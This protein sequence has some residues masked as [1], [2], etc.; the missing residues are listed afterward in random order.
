MAAPATAYEP[1][2]QSFAAQD[3]VPPKWLKS[4]DYTVD[5]DVI[6]K[7]FMNHYLVRSPY[8]VFPARGDSRLFERTREASALA[9]LAEMSKSR[10]FI[11]S[12]SSTVTTTVGNVSD[13][14]DDPSGAAEDFRSGFSRLARRLGRMGRNAYKRGKSLLL[15]GE[16]SEETSDELT[17]TGQD[18]AKGLLGVNRAYRELARDLGV[19]PYTRNEK[20]RYEIE[21]LANYS[22]AGSLGVRSIFPVLPLLYGAGY[23]ITV[24]NLIWNTHPLDLQ[25]RNETLLRDMGMS[26]GLITRLF[27]SEYHT[28][29][30]QTR[31][32][33]SLGLLNGAKGR[34]VLM[35]S[36]SR[37]PTVSD[38]LFYTRMIEML[39]MYHE[40]RG[41]IEEVFATNRI[42]Y[43]LSR[44]E[45]AV[46]II[47]VDHLRWTR[48]ADTLITYMGQQ[49]SRHRTHIEIW[50]TGKVSP[51]AR[52]K[53]GGK[54][55]AVFDRA[56]NRI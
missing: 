21:R 37:V 11:D 51:M 24:S 3:L 38:A 28:L 1:D 19:D 50:V 8:G 34:S 10:L 53:L 41:G 12:A 4:D 52:S 30:T 47:P 54:G 17:R 20:L 45:R 7:L 27:E 18:L 46:L 5:T 31:V 22:A 13:A 56:G 16:N 2:V 23:L 42:P 55:W 43:A 14:L 6:N 25:L 9:R 26:E 44:G 40:R 35:R 36:V 49:M 48:L 29:T 15:E 33:N 32:A 39:A